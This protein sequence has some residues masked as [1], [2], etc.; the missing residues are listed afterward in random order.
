MARRQLDLSVTLEGG[1]REY[2]LLGFS[3]RHPKLRRGSSRST[4]DGRRLPRALVPVDDDQAPAGLDGLERSLDQSRLVADA[5]ERVRHDEGG[6]WL[7]E[8]AGQVP[9]VAVNR[10]DVLDVPLFGELVELIEQ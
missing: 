1:R 4:A 5:V 9:G 10:D 3:G 6:D 7:G 8:D 2:G